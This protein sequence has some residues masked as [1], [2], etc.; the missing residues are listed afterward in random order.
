MRALF[1]LVVLVPMLT[2]VADDN[3][4]FAPNQEW[5]YHTRPQDAG[6]TIVIG[7]IQDDPKMGREEAAEDSQRQT[8]S[9]AMA[10][11]QHRVRDHQTPRARA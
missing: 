2:P 6:S 1:L 3:P 10:R 7:L 4:K 5:S 11:T 8:S 9:L